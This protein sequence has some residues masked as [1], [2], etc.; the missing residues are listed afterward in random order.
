MAEIV[1]PSSAAGAGSVMQLD[2]KKK[3]PPAGS[4]S[5][6]VDRDSSNS[7]GKSNTATLSKINNAIKGSEKLDVEGTDLLELL[8]HLEGELQARDVVIAALKSEQLKRVL[9]GCYVQG[10]SSASAATS[11]GAINSNSSNSASSN[12]TNKCRTGDDQLLRCPLSSLQ[13]DKNF[14]SDANQVEDDLQASASAAE[15]QIVALQLVIEKQRSAASRMAECLRASE[16]QRTTLAQQLQQERQEKKQQ[17]NAA[18]G[19]TGNVLNAAVTTAKSQLGGGG[20]ESSAQHELD[21]ERMAQLKQE[22]VQELAEKERLETALKASTTQLDEEKARQK[23]IVLVLLSDRKKLHR[24]YREEKKRSEDL[25]QML[26]EEKGKMETM[27]VGLEEE[28]KRSLAMEAE[29]EKHLAQFAAERQQLR[30]KLV[31]DE[32]RYRDLEETLRKA[33]LDVE[34]FKKQLAEA[35]RVAMSQASPPPPYPATS[36]GSGGGSNSSSSSSLLV[37]CANPQPPAASVSPTPLSTMIR[38]PPQHQS[39]SMGGQGQASYA[40]YSGYATY[41]T[42]GSGGGVGAGGNSASLNSNPVN[43]AK[44][45][46]GGVS[47]TISQ[48]YSVP[49][50]LAA[51]TG[52]LVSRTMAAASVVNTSRATQ[53]NPVVRSVSGNITNSGAVLGASQ[54]GQ[55]QAMPPPAHSQSQQHKFHQVNYN[56]TAGGFGHSSHPALLPVGVGG[57]G[58]GGGSL[59]VAG[60]GPSGLPSHPAMMPAGGTLSHLDQDIPSDIYSQISKP[61]QAAIATTAGIAVKSGIAGGGGPTTSRKQPIPPPADTVAAVGGSS[62]LQTAAVGNTAVTSRKPGLGKGVPPPV[63]PNK[64]VVPMKKEI[65]SKQQQLP[66][67]I[68]SSSKEQL[69]LSLEAGKQSM[70]TGLQ[71][72]K[73][74]ISIGGGGSSGAGD[75]KIKSGMPGMPSMPDPH[76]VTGAVGMQAKKFFNN[77][78]SKT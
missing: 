23:Q 17:L 15:T 77:I 33:R 44:M 48:G 60:G 54:Q 20:E 47:A 5:A 16:Q 43:S 24:L 75:S 26:Q 73:F 1:S 70:V 3:Q 59:Q 19:V 36:V 57:G 2:K 62:I 56:S 27:A 45:V 46:G 39:G 38:P 7:I 12:N 14:I 6:A 35:H 10:S 9:Y 51:N 32:R 42:A 18:A 28:S 68:A 49:S 69:G 4:S 55:S 61:S 25:A 22:L 11:G 58:G 72:L 71:G 74:G 78:E 67:S 52:T 13:R 53:G 63:P 65:G 21:K 40:A 34:H 76:T 29:L 41:G 50:V 37:T 66:S 30:D 8:S 64:P 31:V